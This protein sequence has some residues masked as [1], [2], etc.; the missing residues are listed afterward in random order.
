MSYLVLGNLT[1]AVLLAVSGWAKLR[2]TAETRDAFQALRLPEWLRRSPAP[3]LLPWAEL[4][5]AVVLVLG[6]GWVL[7]AGSV[8]AVAL[9][10]AYAVVIGQALRFDEPVR[11]N[12]FGALGS[13]DVS[14][15]TLVR[16]LLLLLMAVLGVMGVLVGVELYN[17]EGGSWGWVAMA[18]LSTVVVTLSLVPGRDAGAGT[19]DRPLGFAANLSLTDAETGKG[20]QLRALAHQHRGMVLLFVVAGCG[21]CERVL[22]QLPE[23]L[24]RVPGRVIVPVRPAG[25][26]LH[27]PKWTDLTHLHDDWGSNVA[28]ALVG[29]YTPAAVELD[30]KGAVVGSPAVGEKAVRDLILRT[31]AEPEAAGAPAAKPEPEAV[32][33]EPAVV[34]EDDG[35]EDYQRLPIPDGV[36]LR[37]DGEPVTLRALAAQHAQLLVTIDCLCAPAREA[38]ARVG[39]WQRRLPVLEAKLVPSIRPSTGTLTREVEAVSLYDHDGVAA[40]ALRATGKVAAVLLGADG[41]I[42]GGPVSGIDAVEE[43]VADIEAQLPPSE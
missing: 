10:A 31:A 15:R 11:C 28:Q 12:C 23:W 7:V 25:Y 35:L 34:E 17:L 32:E 2:A 41:M 4:V 24:A 5:L 27:D 16:N 3:S 14:W 33:P 8:A 36:L 38:I 20:V 26:S 43:F 1:C 6:T 13:H 39:E 22:A 37:P 42:A 9:F 19:G 18:A 29:P 40:R 21:G 30:A